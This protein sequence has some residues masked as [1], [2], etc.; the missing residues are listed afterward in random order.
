MIGEEELGVENVIEAIEAYR[1]RRSGSE[2]QSYCYHS[3]KQDVTY[4]H[5]LKEILLRKYNLA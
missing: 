1:S 5:L 2:G 4:R 3:R